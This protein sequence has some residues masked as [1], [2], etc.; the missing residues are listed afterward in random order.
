LKLVDVDP[1]IAAWKIVGADKKNEAKSFLNNKSPLV[2]IQGQIR[3]SIGDVF[4]DLANV[5]EKSEPAN[6]WFDAKKVL[7]E[8]DKEVLVKRE[9][10]GIEIAFLSY[11]GLWQER[12][13]YIVFGDVTHWAYLPEPPKEI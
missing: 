1:I 2:Y 8:K 6:I 11:D 10:F 13:E 12:D 7:P 5:L 3:N 9:K 4:L